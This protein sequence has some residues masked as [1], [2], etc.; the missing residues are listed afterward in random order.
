MDALTLISDGR[1]G[2]GGLRR[3]VRSESGGGKN[4]PSCRLRIGRIS[5]TAPQSRRWCFSEPCSRRAVSFRVGCRPRPHRYP[6]RPYC[7]RADS[8]SGR[9]VVYDLGTMHVWLV[10]QDG[11]VPA[12]TRYRA[13]RPARYRAPASSGSS[14]VPATPTWSADQYRWSSWFASPAGAEVSP[15]AS[16]AS[17]L[18]TATHPVRQPVG[19]TA[20]GGLRTPGVRGRAILVRLGAGGDQRR[21]DRQLRPGAAAAGWAFP[22]G[23]RPAIRRT[24]RL[25]AERHAQLIP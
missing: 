25:Q 21:R 14:P 11:T 8:G 4:E 7:F 15:S 2:A 10:E 24:D 12:T 20:V 9:R 16:T 5:V 22:R 1:H 17:P 6:R 23:P 19:P 3:F 18:C 13:T